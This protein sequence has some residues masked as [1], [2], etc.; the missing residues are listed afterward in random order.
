MNQIN[1]QYLFDA[2]LRHYDSPFEKLGQTIQNNVTIGT[3]I[4]FQEESER[5]HD[6][7]VDGEID[8]MLMR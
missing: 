2:D 4:D 8:D 7:I 1:S 6:M 5:L 3:L